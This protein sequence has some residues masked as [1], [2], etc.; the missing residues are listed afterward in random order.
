MTPSVEERLRQALAERAEFTTTSPGAW[1]GIRARMTRRPRRSRLVRPAV[2]LPGVAVALV[3]LVG[4]VGLL[5]E[6]GATR[7]RVAGRPSGWYLVPTGVERFRLTSAITDPSDSGAPPWEGTVRAFGRRSADGLTLSASLVL[8]VPARPS[9]EPTEREPV[10]LNVFGEDMTVLRD[11]YGRR[12]VTWRGRD[13]QMVGLT[14]FGL[15]TEELAAAIEPFRQGPTPPL[16]P[17]LPMGFEVIYE[18]G[19]R[20]GP[21]PYTEQ[22]WRADDSAEFSIRN[23]GDVGVQ[24]ARLEHLVTDYPGARAVSVRNTTALFVDHAGGFLTWVE[25]P[26]SVIILKGRGLGQQQLQ[27]IANGLHMVDEKAWREVSSRP[28]EPF[29]SIRPV[30]RFT[31][32]PCGPPTGQSTTV[33]AEVHDGVEVGCYEVGA[34]SVTA[35][36]VKSAS[37]KVDRGPEQWVVEFTLSDPAEDRLNVLARSVGVGGQIAVVVDGRVQGAPRIAS[38]SLPGRGLVPGLDEIGARRLADRLRR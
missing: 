18:G 34:P 8:T 33:L 27:E 11:A 4:A 36:D 7:L 12:S 28:A 1:A 10:M 38:L 3:V 24:P 32:A 21:V 26:G 14:G 23:V 2:L 6:D 35:A 13:G 29:F 15:S 30:L 20:T 17:G 31:A 37:A 5:R 19:R 22:R 9:L 25:P 16:P